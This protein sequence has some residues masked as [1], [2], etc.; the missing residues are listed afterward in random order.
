LYSSRSAG[1]RA[2]KHARAKGGIV[3]AEDPMANRIDTGVTVQKPPP[4][5]PPQKPGRRF[6]WRLWL[7]ALAMT[8]AAGAGGYYTYQFHKSEGVEKDAHA[9]CEKKLAGQQGSAD[10]SAKKLT[11]C[12]TDLGSATVQVK[13]LSD[14][15]AQ[16]GQHLDASQGELAQLRAA[17]AE[18]DKRMAAIADIQK[19]FARMI[20]TGQLRVTARHGELVLSLPSEVLFPSGS[21]ELSKQGEYAVVQVAGV[22]RR[23][24]E[25]RY[26]VVGHTDNQDI[27]KPKPGAPAPACAPIDNWQLSTERALTVTRVMV[28]A[29]MDPKNLLPAGAGEHDPV[30]SNATADGRQKNRRIEIALLP[31]INELPPLPPSLSGSGAGSAAKPATGSASP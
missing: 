7:Y 17:K 26:L 21:A 28:T 27:A 5:P 2:H 31:A 4:I 1:N 15:L 29:G 19:Q 8:A 23:Y 11:A 3:G 24:P 25:R 16:T 10:A 12:E 20:D 22:L 14:Q 6:P 30:A 9:V 13:Q 18:A